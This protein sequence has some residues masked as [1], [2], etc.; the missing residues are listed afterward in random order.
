M[1]I[2]GYVRVSTPAQDLYVQ[3]EAVR[4][5]GATMIFSDVGSGSKLSRPGLTSAFNYLRDGD[6]LVVYRLDRLARSLRELLE[7]V[8]KLEDNQITLKSL[9]EAIDLSTPAGRLMVQVFGA[10]GEF[11]RSLIL[12]RSKDGRAAAE[13]LGRRGGRPQKLSDDKKLKL[14][15][16]YTSGRPIPQI[17]KDLKISE[18]TYR[19]MVKNLQRPAPIDQDPLI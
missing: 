11:E 4:A 16:M 18:S 14:L 17:C 12:E 2:V 13:R 9:H 10:I 19:R 8:R 6:T 15:R 1:A 5:A 7:L 3:E